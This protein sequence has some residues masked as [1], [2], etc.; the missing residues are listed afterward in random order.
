MLPTHSSAYKLLNQ[1][2][3]FDRT[4]IATEDDLCCN[5]L[6]ADEGDDDNLAGSY[7]AADDDAGSSTLTVGEQMKSQREGIAA[8]R[9]VSLTLKPIDTN[10]TASTAAPFTSDCTGASDSNPNNSRYRDPNQ[11]FINIGFSNIT[12]TVKTGLWQRGGYNYYY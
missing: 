1:V 9:P 5:A 10:V 2:G 8:R 12:Y 3:N 11:K 4:T 6:Q 7:K